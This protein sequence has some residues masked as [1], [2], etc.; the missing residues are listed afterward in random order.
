MTSPFDPSPAIA[1]G[2]VDLFGGAGKVVEG[3][4]PGADAANA[5][6]DGVVASR[7]WMSDRHNW[8]RVG[9]TMG[10][11][12]LMY[13]GVLMLAKPGIDSAVEAA[14]KAAEVLPVGKIAKISKA[15]PK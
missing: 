5:L 6:I 3:M 8:V 10:G 13:M 15:V 2:L 7:R 9:W 14:G 12:F 1:R 11:A 4:I